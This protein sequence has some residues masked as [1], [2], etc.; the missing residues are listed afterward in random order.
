MS[1]SVLKEFKDQLAQCLLYARAYEQ[2]E[3]VEGGF[4]LD[5]AKRL[6][7]ALRKVH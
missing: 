5:L 2:R 4:V 1:A 6:L 3:K 7:L